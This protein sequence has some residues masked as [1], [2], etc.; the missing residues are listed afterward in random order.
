MV[1]EPSKTRQYVVLEALNHCLPVC[2]RL[3]NPLSVDITRDCEA[4]ALPF[5]GVVIQ[6]DELTKSEP[7]FQHFLFYQTSWVE[8]AAQCVKTQWNPKYIRWLWNVSFT[9]SQ[10]LSV[11]PQITVM[12][13]YY[14]LEEWDLEGILQTI[15]QQVGFGRLYELEVLLISN[16]NHCIYRHQKLIAQYREMWEDATNGFVRVKEYHQ[17]EHEKQTE[18]VYQELLQRVSYEKVY[19]VEGMLEHPFVIIENVF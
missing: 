9:P 14:Q 10:S 11:Y 8:S 7:M 12:V 2:M 15:Q 1:C 16:G 3:Q 18:Q 19:R 5:P 4:K 13:G 17:E 6:Y